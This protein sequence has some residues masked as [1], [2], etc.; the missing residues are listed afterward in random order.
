MH[1]EKDKEMKNNKIGKAKRAYTAREDNDTCS[2][3]SSKE[4]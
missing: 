4:D 2:N 3:Y 1:R